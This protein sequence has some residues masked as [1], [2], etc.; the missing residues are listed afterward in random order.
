VFALFGLVAGSL[1]LGLLVLPFWSF[2]KVMRL[3]REVGHLRARIGELERVRTA[4]PTAPAPAHAA[5]PAAASIYAETSRPAAAP[6]AAPPE[7]VA[8]PL[9]FPAPP[10]APH[11]YPLP[12]PLSSAEESQRKP[13]TADVAAPDDLE[14]RVGGRWLLYVGISILLIGISFFLKYAFDNQWIDQ[15]GRVA[16]GV[17]GG[18]MLVATG[19]RMARQLPAFGLA[20]TGTGLAT[21]YL[22]I[23]A[24]LYFYALIS[25]GAAFVMMA[26]I[27]VLATLLADRAGAQALAMIAAAGGYATPFLITSA[28]PSASLLFSYDLLLGA[29]ALV[30]TRRHR[31]LALPALAY[32][33]TAATVLAWAGEH[34]RA[35]QWAVVLGFLTAFCVLF[36]ELLRFVRRLEGSDASVVAAVLWTAPIA[37]HMA[38]VAVTFNHAPALHV[39][40]LVATAVAILLGTR[41]GGGWLRLPMLLAAYLPLFAY[42]DQFAGPSWL[43]PNMVTS[44]AIAGMHLMAVVDRVTRHEHPRPS[45]GDLAVMHATMI[46]L[47]GLLAQM[48]ASPYPE[49]SG[50]AAASLA[51]VSS[52]LWFFFER[53]APLAAL[54][55]AALAFTLVAIALAARFEGPVVV[56]GWAVEGAAAAWFG[57]RAANAPFRLGGLVLF[58]LAAGRLADGYFTVAAAQSAVL[59]D[60]T[61]ATAVVVLLAYILASQW[62]QRQGSSS[63][64]RVIPIALHVTASVFTLLWMSAEISEYWN[65]RRAESQARLSEELMRSLSWGAYGSIL[66]VVGMW[67]SLVSIRWIGI[68]VIGMT[69]LKVFF[70]DLSELGGIYR[71]VG[72]LVLGALL[73]AVSYLYQR[74]RLNQR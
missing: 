72:F 22:S 38:A 5:S 9:G 20:L 3:A 63:S 11:N 44:I 43:W 26:A 65:R 16:F 18:L 46:G 57:L 25:P 55:A 27:T 28:E 24:A 50:G 66:V 53:R 60:R 59:N 42:V 58:A 39:Y 31:W 64:E 61:A 10:A 37:Y 68:A 52:G 2:I 56:V 15:R 32:L 41:I 74:R 13:P 73:V 51:L 19:W 48:L 14:T 6:P 67:R 62:R 49:W 8:V 34:Y 30:L 4:G 47:Y 54:N 45:T 69:V 71:V 29:G 7:P 36:I 1:A 40:L 33:L 21:L 35:S 70:V 23:Y 17:I 12:T